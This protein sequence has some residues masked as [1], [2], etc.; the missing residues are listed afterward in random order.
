ME[1]YG[2][3]F[4][5]RLCGQPP[6]IRE[7]TF[8]DTEVITAGDLCSLQSGYIDL[9]AS[10]DKDFIGAAVEYVSGTTLVSKIK[11]IVD[12]DA[13]Y[14]VTDAN[15][16]TAGTVLDITGTTGAM[17]LTTDS[18]HDVI[19][20]ENSTATE[21]TLVTFVKGTHVFDTLST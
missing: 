5:Y 10:D 6:T 18:D 19:V 1:A 16:R 8:A 2:F 14:A 4:R 20:V 13:V 12:T 3:H 9:A 15:A 17:A 21:P 7:Y 11:V